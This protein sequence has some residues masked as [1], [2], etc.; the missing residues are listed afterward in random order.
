M[1]PLPLI[2]DADLAALREKVSG[3]MGE[4]RLRHTLS[5]EEEAVAMAKLYL[6]QN[7]PEIR[8]AA[9]LHDITKECS[10]E[11][12]LALCKRYGLTVSEEELASPK[13]LHAKTAAAV[14]PD[15][16]PAF[17]RED[18]LD[19]IAKHTTGAAEMSIFAKILYLADY[20]EK[21]RAFP[22]C[23]KLRKYFWGV[24]LADMTKAERLVHL[25]KTLLMSFEMTIADLAR[26]GCTTATATNE[27]YAA[28]ARALGVKIDT[29]K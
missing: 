25:D 13:I 1:Q 8:A 27:A 6:P 17:A 19:A 28:T 20:T 4:Y 12:Q 2:T 10:F 7:I 24:P 18:I 14:I 26:E 22:D 15:R 29:K 23:I 11:E 5:V 3:E 21:T 9:L 16:Y